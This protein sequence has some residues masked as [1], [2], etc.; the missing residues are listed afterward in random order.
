MGDDAAALKEEGNTRFKAKDY[1]AAIIA[2]TRSL[3]LDP[4]QHLCYSNRSAAYLKLGNSAQEAL[5]DAQRCVELQPD[6]GKGYNRLASALQELKRWDEAAEACRKGMEVAPGEKMHAELLQHVESRRFQ[7]HML[8]TWHGRVSDELGGY[9]QEMEFREN[10]SVRIEVL[11]KALV[12]RYWL[13]CSQSPTC[14]EVQVPAAYSDLPAGMPPP[15]PVPYIVKVDDEG[16]HLCC[17]YMKLERPRTFEGPGYVLM[18]KGPVPQGDDDKDIA[19]MSTTE[20]QIMCARELLAIMPDEKISEPDPMENE[21]AQGEKLMLQL[22]FEAKMFSVTKRFGESTLREVL[23]ATKGTDV[24][25]GLQGAK[26]L[27]ALT[28][29]M[30]KAGV[31]DMPA[32]TAGA[33]DPQA[34]R[35]PSR[36]G[37]P[38]RTPAEAGPAGVESKA[39]DR[40]A[41]DSGSQTNTV[42]YATAAALVLAVAVGVGLT[43]MRRRK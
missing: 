11:G 40:G 22:R 19:T 18:K 34:S 33:A 36:T 42:M 27:A 4:Q 35:T 13:D 38:V 9:D 20:K 1:A 31:W 26:E 41:S 6:W 32:P 37:A 5:A 24:P 21:E 28:E 2:Y 14:M 43:F 23:S 3:E 12:G 8:G 16:L 39:S 25:A 15:P 10:S 7:E 29:K 30:K 17:P